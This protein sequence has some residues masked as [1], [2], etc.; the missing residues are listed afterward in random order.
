M[1]TDR[2]RSWATVVGMIA[3]TLAA[4]AGLRYAISPN[5]S[6]SGGGRNPDALPPGVGIR[7]SQTEFTGYDDQGGQTRKSWHVR[8][9]TV[10]FS[11]DRSRMEAR[12]NV[13]AEIFDA[14]TGKRRALIRAV[15]VVFTRNS[16]TL[17]VGGK[18]VCQAPGSNDESD[19]R[20]EADT[21]IWNVGAKQILCPGA[22]VADLPNGMGETRGRDLTLD[23]TS[24]E[25][26]LNKFHGTFVAPEGEGSTPPPFINPLKGLPF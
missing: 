19:L 7:V 14:P 25:L 21:L 23:L 15:T 3:L 26:V 12:G 6:P 10:D 20:V 1:N 2:A 11:S 16:K 8:A 22:I 24:R 13:E 9:D 4:T 18:I 17:Q 5:R